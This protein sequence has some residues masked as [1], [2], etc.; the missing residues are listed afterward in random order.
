MERNW[1]IDKFLSRYT[2]YIN[3]KAIKWNIIGWRCA[4]A[5]ARKY[6]VDIFTNSY[7]IVEILNIYTGEIV[8]LQEAER[9]A[10]KVA[11]RRH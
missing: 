4:L 11:K 10:A 3:G 5:H 7:N 9:R 8:S 1:R 6:A 2:V